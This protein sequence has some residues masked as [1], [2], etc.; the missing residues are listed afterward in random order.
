MKDENG[1]KKIGKS[2]FKVERSEKDPHAFG[3][4]KK[5]IIDCVRAIYN[6][7]NVLISGARGIGKSS[8]GQQMQIV[9]QGDSTLLE[10][11]KIEVDFP[12]T[13][14]LYYA[15]SIGLSLEQL[16]LDLLYRLEQAYRI[17]QMDADV[18]EIKQGFELNLGFIKAN[19]EATIGSST[20]GAPATLATQFVD[21]LELV[22][23]KI[24]LFRY[25]AISIMLDEVDKLPSDANLGGF[26]KIVHESLSSRDLNNVNFI[27][28]GQMGIFT[29]LQK[30][31]P[32]F[33][34]LIKHVPLSPLD[35]DASEYI[36]DYAT[37]N[38]KPRINIEPD[39][40]QAILG[41]AAGHPDTI[42]LVGDAAFYQAEDPKTITRFDVIKGIMGILK[43]DKREKYTEMLQSVAKDEKATLFI[44]GTY[45]SEAVPVRIPY[46]WLINR[47]GK[48]FSAEE[49]DK[50][51]VSLVE[52]AYLVLKDDRKSI[53]F[54]EELFRLFIMLGIMEEQGLQIL[55]E[56]RE[57]YYL[58]KDK[59]R[60]EFKQK[61]LITEDTEELDRESY[62]SQ[63]EDEEERLYDKIISQLDEVDEDQAQA[64]LLKFL[65]NKDEKI[66]NQDV[67]T[68]DGLNA[69]VQTLIIKREQANLIELNYKTDWDIDSIFKS[70]RK[71]IGSEYGVVGA[72]E[73]TMSDLEGGY[74]DEDTRYFIQD[75]FYRYNDDEDDD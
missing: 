74:D 34:R 31:H 11:C 5:E 27:L 64:I 53:Y 63:Q 10:R 1:A 4:R 54:T 43:S 13:F 33:E 3:L 46:Q 30:E 66:K 16:V 71:F 35:L 68:L 20:K 72:E 39:A 40:K 23:K 58:N 49:I 26:M 59:R 70:S 18:K 2:P 65:E 17:L 8:L 50:N 62:V 19:V 37:K 24:H 45:R 14:C 25:K 44:L 9:L 57:T 7:R 12:K 69:I 47:A 52:Q 42:H 36:L 28:A 60:D 48:Y 73:I 15:C 32:S 56:E 6:N 22:F 38:T 75:N 67:A 29:R 21:G 55:R 51:L 41:I 61:T